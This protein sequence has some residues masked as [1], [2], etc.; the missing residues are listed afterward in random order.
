MGGSLESFI[1]ARNFQ[2]RSKSRNFLIFGPSGS[3]RLWRSRRRK[4]SSVP[5]GATSFPA[6]VFL[7]GKCSELSRQGQWPHSF[8]ELLNKLGYH[9]KKMIKLQ[10]RLPH[11]RRRAVKLCLSRRAQRVLPAPL[12][13]PRLRRRNPRHSL[14]RVRKGTSTAPSNGAPRGTS[15]KGGSAA[16]RSQSAPA[17]SA[18]PPILFPSDWPVPVKQ[19]L[20]PGQGEGV[21]LAPTMHEAKAT[22][23]QMLGH[24][25]RI[26]MICLNKLDDKN[27]TQEQI[28]I[29]LGVRQGQGR[30]VQAAPVWLVQLGDQAVHPI[31]T[32]QTIDV[33]PSKP[34]TSVTPL[35][36]SKKDA[37]AALVKQLSSGEHVLL[38]QHVVDFV[39]EARKTMVDIFRL[40]DD[41]D[42]LENLSSKEYRTAT[43][44]SSFLKPPPGVYPWTGEGRREFNG[45]M[46]R[47]NRTESL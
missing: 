38:K 28:T 44:F 40:K 21:S 30:R 45:Q 4:S 1:L 9:S 31:K 23:T 43:A 18:E 11:R 10:H 25:G 3:K 32:V 27:V 22:L 29:S 6:A 17:S 34:T 15:G 46:N 2:S 26:A 47:G 37:D 24:K 14:R 8:A 42:T 33:K 5:E 35:L 13:P 7:A 41:G 19:R 36:I 16:Q 12:L 20:L 39:D